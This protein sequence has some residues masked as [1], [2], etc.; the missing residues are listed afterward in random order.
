MRNGQAA[1]RVNTLS[2]S[3][4]KPVLLRN[5]GALCAYQERGKQTI[6]HEADVSRDTVNRYYR[7]AMEAGLARALSDT[8]DLPPLEIVWPPDPRYTPPAPLIAR[9]K[10][11]SVVDLIAEHNKSE[12]QPNHSK[13]YPSPGDTLGT[14][15]GQAQEGGDHGDHD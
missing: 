5:Y 8:V 4:Y 1:A 13:L 6:V 15:P 12:S 7:E 11:K 10:A 2:A 14:W 9:K 3:A